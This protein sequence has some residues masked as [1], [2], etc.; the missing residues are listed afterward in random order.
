VSS[1]LPLDGILL[2]M[3]IMAVSCIVVP[4]G[5]LAKWSMLLLIFD[6]KGY[7][8][9]DVFLFFLTRCQIY[10]HWWFLCFLIAFF[11]FVWC[12]YSLMVGEMVTCSICWLVRNC[13][14]NL[15]WVEAIL[16]CFLFSFPELRFGYHWCLWRLSLRLHLFFA[17]V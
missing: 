17:G 5:L 13:F 1:G 2:Y 6:F 8:S 4:V 14:L 9:A 11:A 12:E 15:I 7:L 10:S 3:G 16:C